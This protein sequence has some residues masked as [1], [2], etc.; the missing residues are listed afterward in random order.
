MQHEKTA[1]PTALCKEMDR[2]R[3]DTLRA[4]QERQTAAAEAATEKDKAREEAE[5]IKRVARKERKKVELAELAAELPAGRAAVETIAKFQ[6]VA[7]AAAAIKEALEEK[8]LTIVSHKSQD[9]DADGVLL[10]PA[11]TFALTVP[12]GSLSRACTRTRR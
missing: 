4:E 8:T 12:Q 6:A 7:K 10:R 2:V 5:R 9:A 11:W 3:L 1:G